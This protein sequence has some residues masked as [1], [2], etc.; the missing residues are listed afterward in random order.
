MLLL[1]IH[2]IIRCPTIKYRGDRQNHI[3]LALLREIKNLYLEKIH[4]P[5][6]FSKNKF[7]T[8]L[9]GSFL[10]IPN[11]LQLPCFLINLRT[12]IPKGPL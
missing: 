2:K 7:P 11:K 6:I 1:N 5:I 3:N 8:D 4:M 10:M 12:L 9:F